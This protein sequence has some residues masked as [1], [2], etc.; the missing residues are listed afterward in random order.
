VA[1][2][3]GMGWR[4]SFRR[5]LSA[6][7]MELWCGLVNIL[8]QITL[9]DAIDRPSWKWTKNGQFSVKSMYKKN[10]VVMGWIGLSNTFGRV[11]SL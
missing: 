1:A 11:K 3:A 7:L 10:S 2:A 6:G 9:T 8:Q 5:W 4:L